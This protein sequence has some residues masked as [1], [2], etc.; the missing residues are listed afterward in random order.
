[1]GERWQIIPGF[2]RYEV[3]D[4]GR[5][6]YVLTGRERTLHQSTHGYIHVSMHVGP[7]TERVIGVRNRPL[8]RKVHRL[9]AAAFIPN[10]ESKS[11][12]NHIDGDRKNN[13]VSN[14]EWVTPKENYAHAA[15]R[16]LHSSVTNPN[17]IHKMTPEAREEAR[18]RHAAGENLSA[19]ARAL[20]VD[21]QT[22][23]RSVKG[24]P[25]QTYVPRP[26]VYRSPETRAASRERRLAKLAQVGAGTPQ[27]HS[28]QDDT[29]KGISS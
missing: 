1:M 27:A 13:R 11:E 21:R 23:R 9:V 17:R 2:E 15:A 26:G 10:P 20:G 19:I 12:V 14:L 28:P 7:L 29:L 24:R 6:R 16:G 8:T 22:I 18:R 25:P 5:I 3:S 4:D